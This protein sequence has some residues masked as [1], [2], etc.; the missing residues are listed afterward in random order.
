MT[1]GK[2][3]RPSQPDP[4]KGAGAGKS[5]T[6][7]GDAGKGGSTPRS[8][9]SGAAGRSE[10]AGPAPAADSSAVAVAENPNLVTGAEK[11]SVI[12]RLVLGSALM[13]FVEL[14]LIRWLGANVVHL[15]YFSNFV[16]LGSF[17]G[18]GVGFLIS[19]RTWSM[20]PVV[21]VVLAALVILVLL[22]PVQIKDQ[23]GSSIIY[24]TS[25]DTSGPP[26]WLILPIIFVLV[27]FILS[28]PAEV[29]GPVLREAAAADVLPVRPDRVADRHR[30]RSPWCRSCGRRRMSGASW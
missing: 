23:V 13:L 27:A 8:G 29:V 12:A 5:D 1:T 22:F 6:G 25:L 14:A 9:K 26:A 24:F 2:A 30:A 11:R 15:S 28:G 7:R 20:L 18:I 17:L 19:R 21:P 4:K 16:L 3:S 10:S